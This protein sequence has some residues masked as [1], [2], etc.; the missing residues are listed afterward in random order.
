MLAME[1]L[2]YV[3]TCMICTCFVKVNM[4]PMNKGR[5]EGRRLSV[6]PRAFGLAKHMYS[7]RMQGGLVALKEGKSPNNQDKRKFVESR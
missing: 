1:E 3:P 2:L 5:E 7:L 4:L 6:Q